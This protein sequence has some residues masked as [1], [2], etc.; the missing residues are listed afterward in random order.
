MKKGLLLLIALFGCAISYA[1]TTVILKPNAV[2]GKDASVWRYD[3]DCIPEGATQTNAERNFGAEPTLWMKDWTWGHIGCSGGTIRSLLCFTELNSI[4]DNAIILS[5]KLRLFGT[6]IDM[7]S[8][9]PGAPSAFYSNEVLVEEITSYWSENTVTWNNQPQTTTANQF[10]IPQSNSQYNWNCTVSN[11]NL[12]AMVQNMVSGNNYGFML[13]LQTE[14][15]YRNMVFSSSDCLDST[16]WPELEIT[17]KYCNAHF[18]F[19][20]ENTGDKSLK[21]YFNSI[22]QGGEHLWRL[23]SKQI[24]TS[25]SF[26]Y[27]LPSKILD[28]TL[29]HQVIKDFDTCEYC[30]ELCFANQGILLTESAEE[31]DDVK[32]SSNDLLQRKSDLG[33]REFSNESSEKLKVVPNPTNDKWSIVFRVLEKSELP[34]EIYNVKGEKVYS[35]KRFFNNGKNEIDINCSDWEVGVYVLKIVEKNTEYTIKLIKQ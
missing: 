11:P 24:S 8:S 21:F 14:E 2:V 1:Q 23:G 35:E 27:T 34:I 12:V 13:K 20:L 19:C 26:T 9:Y 30:I 33:D 17:Y 5:A 10:T 4:P 28:R 32:I 15:H 3:N 29:C 18:S 25:P 22:E 7:N 31:D 6:N 16:L